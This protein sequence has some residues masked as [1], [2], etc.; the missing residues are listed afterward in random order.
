MPRSWSGCVSLVS[1]PR[2]SSLTYFV[3]NLIIVM[4]SIR[5]MPP[6]KDPRPSTEPS[7]PYISQLGEAIASAIQSVICPPQRTPLETVYNLKL[8]TFMGTKGHA[9]SKHWL[10]HVEKTFQVMQSQGSLSADRWVEIVSWFL[11]RE[12]ASW[13]NQEIYWWTIEEKE[14]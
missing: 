5:I 4:F 3:S 12:P 8:P 14:N 13:W 10:E 6:R 1:E 9:G 11:D 7:F 2:F